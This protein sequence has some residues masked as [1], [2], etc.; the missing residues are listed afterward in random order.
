MKSY[1]TSHK[2]YQRKELK[3]NSETC[4]QKNKSTGPAFISLYPKV[5][6]DCIH[7]VHGIDA[8]IKRGVWEK[9][10][11]NAYGTPVVPFRKALLPGQNK[12]KIRVCGD[13]SMTINPQLKD[14]H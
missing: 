12:A 7:L 2:K 3:I 5:Y 9:T 13:Y 10:N 1:M 4:I 14:H 11:F 8:G 6:S